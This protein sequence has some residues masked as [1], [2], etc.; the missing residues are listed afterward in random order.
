MFPQQVR[1]FRQP[2]LS[3]SVDDFPRF[4]RRN[5]D[6]NLPFHPFCRELWFGAEWDNAACS[7][8]VHEPHAVPI[9]PFK[10]TGHLS[11]SFLAGNQPE[12]QHWRHPI[13]RVVN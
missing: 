13:N 12:L 11:P 1:L 2:D 9:F 5:Q 4:D 7:L 6:L 8:G 10:E 3:F